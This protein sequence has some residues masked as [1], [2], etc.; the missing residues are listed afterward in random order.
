MNQID[1]I[2]KLKKIN[3]LKNP[4]IERA[5]RE[6]DRADFV[7]PDLRRQAYED[8][9]LPLGYGATI[10]QPYAVVFMLELLDVQEGD[11]IM[12]IGYGSGWLT[13]LL[14]YLT[15]EKGKVYAMEITPRVSEI[16]TQNIN[17]YPL[18]AD[19]IEAKCQNAKDGLPDIA[20]NLGGFHKIIAAAEIKEDPVM[21]RIQLKDGGTL[22]YPR[23][24]GIFKETKTIGEIKQDFF[25][26]F[27]FVPFIEE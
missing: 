6:V 5:I 8:T 12:E 26:G 23:N 2:D 19:I 16:G 7:N 11:N 17:K 25:P 20:I 1:L 18:Y 4:K 27:S 14:A 21:W 9:A 10:S 13:M 24:G 15:G 3:V 22:I